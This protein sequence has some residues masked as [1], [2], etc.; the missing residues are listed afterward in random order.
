MVTA[1]DNF[2][3][4]DPIDRSVSVNQGLRI[5]FEG[6]ARAIFRLSGTGTEGATLR[7]YV[8]HLETDSSKL[9]QDAQLALSGVIA[10]AHAL[11]GIESLGRE[12]PDV[13]T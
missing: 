10:A 6:G 9:N 2:S 8:E 1:A 5:Q 12:K 13:I 11:S 4:D 3:Y 7:L